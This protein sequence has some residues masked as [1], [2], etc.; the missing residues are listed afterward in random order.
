MVQRSAT[1]ISRRKWVGDWNKACRLGV[2]EI[3]IDLPI[4]KLPKRKSDVAYKETVVE[5]RSTGPRQGV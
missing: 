5:Q 2:L 3:E 4:P 1:V